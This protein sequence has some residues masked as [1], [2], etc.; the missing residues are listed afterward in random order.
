MPMQRRGDAQLAFHA[1]NCAR[2]GLVT[3]AFCRPIPASPTPRNEP[4]RQSCAGRAN[5]V[6]CVECLC[7]VQLPTRRDVIAAQARN[8]F[9]R[10]RAWRL[11]R[12]FVTHSRD[13]LAVGSPFLWRGR[14]RRLRT[15]RAPWL[16]LQ[17]CSAPSTSVGPGTS[18]SRSQRRKDAKHTFWCG[19]GS[20]HLSPC[21]LCVL[22]RR[23]YPFWMDISQPGPAQ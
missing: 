6:K 21:G 8:V 13:R 3:R 1:P 16:R 15:S 7:L 20:H 5:R 14:A 17:S 9:E 10:R 11:A 12:Y 22:A 19:L 23:E 18:N 2:P 4:Y